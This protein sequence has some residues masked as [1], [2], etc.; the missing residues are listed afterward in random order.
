MGKA[1]FLLFLLFS[2]PRSRSFFKVT[3]YLK[4]QPVFIPTGPF[5]IFEPHD[6]EIGESYVV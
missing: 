2:F 6:Q 1:M 5:S 4:A 3:V